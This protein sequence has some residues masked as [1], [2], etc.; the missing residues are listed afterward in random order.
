MLAMPAFF[1]SF[2]REWKSGELSLLAFALFF[3]MACV[4]ALNNLAEV[5]HYQ[6]D[7]QAAQLLGADRQL[8]SGIVLN[9]EWFAKAS[10]LGLRQSQALSF[11]SMVSHGDN[12]QLAQI[13]AIQTP[14]PLNGR[15]TIARTM[16]RTE[17]FTTNKAPAEGH[18]WMGWRLFP[19]LNLQIGGKVQIGAA[20]FIVDGIIIE[21]P[22]Q[23]GDWFNISPHILMNQSD[24][25]K[26]A[27]I[28]TG[29]NIRYQWLVSGNPLLLD[30]LYQYLQPQLNEQQQWFDSKSGNQA[31]E[32]NT[33]RT[34]AYLN[35]G[36]LMSL[37]LAGVAISMASLRF[38]QRHQQHVALLRCFGASQK[39]IL[40][41]Y[42]LSI[43]F[44]G[45]IASILGIGLGYALKPLL[46]QWLRGITPEMQAPFSLKPALLSF[47]TGILILSAFSLTHLLKLRNTSPVSIFKSRTVQPQG[48]LVEGYA[49]AFIFSAG[50]AYLYTRS[51]SITAVVIMA[52]LLFIVL[53]IFSLHIGFGLL[54][55]A[56][57][58]HLNWR[59]G[60]IS[61]SRNL[62]NSALQIIGMGLALTA[63]LS[64]S[65]L[66]TQLLA[67]WQ[68]QLPHDAANYFLI[69]IEPSQ[70]PS[71]QQFLTQQKINAAPIYPVVRGRLITIN[72]QSI[73]QALGSNAQEI[74][75]LQ[76][77]LNLSWTDSL[78]DDNT[79]TQGQ[80]NTGLSIEEG[81]ANRLGVQVGDKL[82]FRIID[83]LISGEITS[84]RRLN[85]SSFKP[86]FFILFK[87][88]V[89][90][91]F[92]Q[93]SI[94]SLYLPPENR[95]FL[96][97][98]VKQFPNITVIDIATTLEK[99]RTIFE[100][101]GKAISLVSLFG[102]FT[103][104]I[105]TALAMLS[106]TGSKKQ[107]TYLLKTLGMRRKQ[108]LWIKSSEAFFIGFY[109]GLLAVSTAIAINFYV[110]DSLLGISFRMPWFY[111]LTVPFVAA[112][113]TIL[114]SH[115]VSYLQYERTA[116]TL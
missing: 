27:V 70:I 14:F 104:L 37:V 102:L 111:L 95:D 47:A 60:F 90:N 39:H 38:S 7:R 89:L 94:T 66:R 53:V 4:S 45:S 34:L 103:G 16:N 69:N 84:I 20:E 73:N 71:L 15:L 29:S 81:L 21:E 35:L 91:S 83:R 78:P 31:V 19:P 68:H 85:W 5:I 1:R 101:V 28:Q 17:Q 100:N 12:L 77:E 13:K 43:L 54:A 11:L 46:I 51:W 24:I 74:N 65:L 49:L 32:K 26:T 98:L 57:Q 80:W 93:T 62:G 10:S 115:T 18:I 108:M 9:K 92:P 79:L 97:R 96:M 63:L 36:T 48:S 76:R 87:P 50:L 41:W 107:E 44:L 82:G 105:I 6:L 86:N 2:I 114:L 22:G 75:A 64:L 99:V 61:I 55:S 58:I 112:L 106:L 33:S 116:A 40:R 42:F 3:A 88:G 109:A 67:D 56:R 8:N 30:Q 113:G 52:C 59:F 25:G 72:D 23:V 110:A